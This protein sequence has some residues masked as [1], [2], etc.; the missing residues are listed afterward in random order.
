MHVPEEYDAQLRSEMERDWARARRAHKRGDW[1]QLARAVYGSGGLLAVETL[2]DGREVVVPQ[3]DLVGL[4]GHVPLQVGEA[5]HVYLDLQEAIL[6]ARFRAEDR[7][8]E[9]AY[10]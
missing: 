5:F 6:E 2:D 9:L 3:R 8:R 10:R 4:T 1:E 7:L